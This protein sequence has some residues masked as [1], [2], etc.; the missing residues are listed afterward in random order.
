MHYVIK[1]ITLYNYDIT[2]AR[3]KII[4]TI[5]VGNSTTFTHSVMKRFFIEEE[6]LA[7]SE[8]KKALEELED[9]ISEGSG[10]LTIH[11]KK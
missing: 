4:I 9:H 8:D 3:L 5:S 1:C 7:A 10:M 2:I 6:T 11:G